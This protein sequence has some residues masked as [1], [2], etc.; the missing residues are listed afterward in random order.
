MLGLRRGIHGHSDVNYYAEGSAEALEWQEGYDAGKRLARARSPFVEGLLGGVTGHSS[1]N[2]YSGNGYHAE[3][4][5]DGYA[6]GATLRE[7]SRQVAVNEGRTEAL[8]ARVKRLEEIL[9]QLQ[10]EVVVLGVQSRMGREAP[11]RAKGEG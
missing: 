11:G 4:W 10:G 2:P 8:T 7:M 3:Q 5:N 9:D 6:V 1:V